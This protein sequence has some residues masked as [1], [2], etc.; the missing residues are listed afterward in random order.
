MQHLK[1]QNAAGLS[2]ILPLSLTA[3]QCCKGHIAPAVS[4]EGKIERWSEGGCTAA[5]MI[6]SSSGKQAT[7]TAMQPIWLRFDSKACL[8]DIQKSLPVGLL[9]VAAEGRDRA[10]EL[11]WSRCS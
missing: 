3:A 10:L 6:A 2:Y 11:T 5:H 9:F 4:L 1:T 8:F 7:R